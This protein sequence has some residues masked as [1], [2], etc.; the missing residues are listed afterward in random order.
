MILY[1]NR[2]INRG[3]FLNRNWGCS[4]VRSIWKTSSNYTYALKIP[5]LAIKDHW[6]ITQRTLIKRELSMPKRKRAMIRSTDYANCEIYQ[7]FNLNM[8]SVIIKLPNKFNNLSGSEKF[9]QC[10]KFSKLFIWGTNVTLESSSW[11]NNR[12]VPHQKVPKK[13]DMHWCIP[14]RPSY[15]SYLC[16]LW[17]QHT[18][19]L[20]AHHLTRP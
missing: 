15:I 12:Q 14:L 6:D 3:K 8:A 19:V 10:F 7:I 11:R 17:K 2:V 4:N 9:K 18:W 13:Y 20:P 5:S 16:R 1:P